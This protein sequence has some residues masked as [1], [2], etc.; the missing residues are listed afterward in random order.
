MRIVD[1]GVRIEEHPALNPQSE[2]RIPQLS[3][4]VGRGYLHKMNSEL[5][6]LAIDAAKAAEPVIMQYY[7]PNVAHELKSDGSPV[8]P[9]DRA[10]EEIIR[11][12]ISARFPDHA[13]LGEEFGTSGSSDHVW[14]IDPIDGTKNFMTG[15]PIFGTQIA[16][17]RNGE[18]VL[19]VSNCPALGEFCYGEKRRGAFLNGKPIQVS[20]VAQLADSRVSMSGQ[21]HFQ[22]VGREEG[23]LRLIHGSTRVRGFGDCW[24]YHLIASGRFEAN[25]EPQI[26]IWDIAAAAA[27]VEA[28]GGRATDINGGPVTTEIR[29]FIASNGLVHDE[30]VQLLKPQ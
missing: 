2:I 13:F 17:M 28:A 20:T 10:A 11:K 23:M 16:L 22:K 4:N 18:L 21:N 9:A 6:Q 19:G 14:I 26:K 27:I 3:P 15:I 12:T 1:C 30:I 29:T 5:L 24:A 8:T 7:G 25:V